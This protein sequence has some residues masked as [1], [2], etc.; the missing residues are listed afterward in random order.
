MDRCLTQVKGLTMHQKS[1][2]GGP[3]QLHFKG[4]AYI[5]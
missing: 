5:A 1:W 2:T 4:L 3:V